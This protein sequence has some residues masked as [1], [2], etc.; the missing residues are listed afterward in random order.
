L[1]SKS[2]VFKAGPGAFEDIKRRGFSEERIGTIAGASGGAKWLSL[3]QMDRVIASRVLPKLTGPVHLIG[4]SI[5]AWRFACYAQ[6]SPLE[7]IERFERL[8]LEQSY[9]DKPDAD[10]ISRVGREIIV[11]LLGESGVQDIVNHPNLRL[12]IMTVRCHHL[13]ASDVRPVLI[14]GLLAAIAA[15]TVSRRS[16]GLFFSRALFFDRRDYPPFFNAPGFPLERIRLTEHNLVDAVMAS[17]SIPLVLKGVR[18]IHGAPAGTYRDGGIIDYHLDLPTSDPDR[19]TLYPHFFDWMKPGWFDRN[20]SWRRL[21]PA[22][23][24]RTLLICPSPEFIA[25][26][27]N[28][29][30]PNRQDFVDFSPEER[31]RIWRQ[32]IDQ[33]RQLADELNDVLDK[34]QIAER[35]QPL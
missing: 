23:T 12:N 15:N 25:T 21:D 4:S 34:G 28:G 9:S 19:I 26:L 17:G 35:L 7:A 20:L 33:C 32:A 11:A 31:V 16:L 27:P 22:N 29:Q 5:G 14:A 8:Y 6:S 3:S 10:E 24:D 2:L 18:D 1:V 13:T 30:V